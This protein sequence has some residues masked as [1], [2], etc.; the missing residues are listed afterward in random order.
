MRKVSRRRI[1]RNKI[2]VNEM[3]KKKKT[4]KDVEKI[5]VD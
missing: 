3:W 5:H 4:I 2:K 1:K